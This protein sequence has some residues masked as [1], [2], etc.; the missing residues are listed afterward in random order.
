MNKIDEIKEKLFI[1]NPD[2]TDEFLE[3][4][5]KYISLKI[6]EEITK[7]VSTTED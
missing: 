7:K 5:Y 2:F 4:L 1:I 3:L 6:T